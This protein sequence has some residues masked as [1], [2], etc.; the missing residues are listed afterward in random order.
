M[1]IHQCRQHTR[2]GTL[3]NEVPA[4]YPLPFAFDPAIRVDEPLP[5]ACESLWNRTNPDRESHSRHH[6]IV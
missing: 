4:D 1:P 2:I 3:L 5:N 6:V